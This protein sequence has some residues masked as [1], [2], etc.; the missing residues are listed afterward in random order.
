MQL[1]QPLSESEFDELDDLLLSDRTAEDCMTMDSLH[2]FLTAL[3][4]GP[5]ET[6]INVWLPHVWSQDANAAPAFKSDKEATHFTNLIARFMNEILITF[7]VAPKEYEPLFCE[8]TTE[9][10]K[11]LLDGQAWA[12]GFWE[13]IQLHHDKWDEI[14]H[15]N[16]KDI[17]RPFYIMGAEEEELTAQEL[18]LTDTPQKVHKLSIEIE[19]AIPHI[20]QYWKPK[21]QSATQPIERDT[22][23]IGR[24]DSCS[25]SS[26]K[27]YKQC[28]GK[29]TA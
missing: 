21:R 14:F 2:G 12:G 10:G 20:F 22:P 1:D 23:K 29:T 13:G 3:A 27:K 16:L 7:E 8:T 24:N 25:C 17:M 18:T 28:C 26:G 19:A 9:D 6:P 4:I 15:S 11:P 5:Q